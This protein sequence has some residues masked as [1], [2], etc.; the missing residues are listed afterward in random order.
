MHN[1]AQMVL[2]MMLAAVVV[3]LPTAAVNAGDV[4]A[5]TDLFI[6][7]NGYNWKINA[8]W[9]TPDPCMWFGVACDAN[10]RVSA[11]SLIGNAL[12]GTLPV[13]LN[14]LTSLQ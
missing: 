13:T 11:V 8:G 9:L 3:P 7:T 6:A 5:L 10:G 1:R 14:K 12:T 4:T 2:A